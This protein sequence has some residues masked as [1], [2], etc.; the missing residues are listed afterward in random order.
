M[1][2]DVIKRIRASFYKLFIRL[3]LILPGKVM[4]IGGSDTLPPPLTREE[5]AELL[6]RL[7]QGETDVRQILIERNLRLVVYIARRFENTGINIEDLISIGTIGLIKAISTYRSDKNIKLATYASRCIENEILMHLRK[8]SSQ[9]TEV[10]L[11]E[12]LNTD[13][14]GNELLLSDVLGT[15]ADTVMRPIE[16]GVDRQLLDAAI[17]KLSQREQEIIVLRFG[18][19]GNREQTQ[20]EVADRLGIS[21]SYISRLEKRIISRLKR[22]ILRMS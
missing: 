1:P 13:W 18:L 14:D 4:Y 8:N 2:H 22:D 7:D 12:P 19:R 21:Q 10:S 5:E 17:A 6:R 16:A 20:K 9:R 15:D 3:K 11:D